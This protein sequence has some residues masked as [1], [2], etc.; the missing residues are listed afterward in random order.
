MTSSASS[1]RRAW[2][3]RRLWIPAAV[4]LTTIAAVQVAGTLKVGFYL[5]ALERSGLLYAAPVLAVAALLV[6]LAYP[7]LCVYAVAFILPFNFVGGV[8]GDSQVV[9]AAKMAVNGA[10][11]ATILMSFVTPREDCAWI[12]R[13][14]LGQA[15]LLWLGMIAMGIGIGFV[16]TPNRGDWLRESMWMSFFGFALPVG[17]LMRSRRDVA[18]LI[19]SAAAGVLVLQTYAFWVLVTGQRYERADAWDAGQTFF[20]APFSPQSLL[21]LYLAAAALLYYASARRLTGWRGGLLVAGIAFLGAGLLASMGRSL[22]ISGA[23]GMA[24]VLWRV[25]WDRRTMKATAALAAGSMLAVGLVVLFDS[26]SAASSQRWLA[27]ATSFFLD[28]ASKDSTSTVT[29]ELEWIHAIDVWKKSPLVGLGFG[30]P[31]PIITLGKVAE[32]VLPDAFYMHNSYLN[33]L[34]KCGAFGLG[35]LLLLVWRTFGGLAFFERLPSDLP[36]EILVTAL[37]AGL[38]QILFYAAFTPVL[39]ASDTVAY[40]GMLVGLTVAA[41]R[42]AAAGRT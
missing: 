31:F 8:W 42:A 34:A 32:S 37:I 28:L 10:L 25:P 2:H 19:A 20:R 12:T 13:T 27:S 3:D 36:A 16:S 18:R 40:F 17:T 30:Y 22:W 39:T 7:R 9:L 26:L 38:V 15:L 21:V 4:A 1:D 35:A 29:R 5:E 14:R 24:V 11:A 23:L 33:I 41:R 6:M